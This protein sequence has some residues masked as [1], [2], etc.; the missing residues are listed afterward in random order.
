M[1]LFVFHVQKISDA[2]EMKTENAEGMS[3]TFRAKC[4]AK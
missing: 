4:D 2:L 1:C 3:V